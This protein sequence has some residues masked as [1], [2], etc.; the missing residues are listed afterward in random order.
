MPRT[1]WEV[2]VEEFD[3]F[4]RRMGI[5]QTRP[6]PLVRIQRQVCGIVVISC[7]NEGFNDISDR[8]N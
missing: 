8:I 5:N 4:L 7:G 6:A 2:E 1:R 3:Q